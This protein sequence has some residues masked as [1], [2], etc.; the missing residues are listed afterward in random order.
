MCWC[1]ERPYGAG[2]LVLQAPAAAEEHVSL[3]RRD[4]ASWSPS[5]RPGPCTKGFNIHLSSG[6]LRR[7]VKP[8]RGPDHR[9][10]LSPISRVLP[11]GGSAAIPELHMIRFGYKKLGGGCCL[12]L[13]FRGTARIPGT[14]SAPRWRLG[15]LARGLSS[16]SGP[17]I[18]IMSHKALGPWGTP[19][20]RGPG[21]P[22][23]RRSDARGHFTR[24]KL[25]PGQ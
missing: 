6:I 15:A 23:P 2:E 19:A 8:P 21:W 10:K 1:S 13:N 20:G 14:D 12:Y 18:A 9:A 11:L 5:G 3:P 22:T 17:F 24:Q 16:E 4:M 25:L 7:A